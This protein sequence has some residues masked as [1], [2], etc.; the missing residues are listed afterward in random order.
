[1]SDDRILPFGIRDNFW[2]MGATG[3]CG[4]CTE[5]HVDRSPNLLNNRS[6]HVNK[7]RAD[8]VEIWNIVFIQY[9]RFCY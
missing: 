3:P 7:D 9:N 8:L 5:V 2:E 1:M 6:R 4:P